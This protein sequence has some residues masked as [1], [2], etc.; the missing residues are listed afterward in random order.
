MLNLF[1]S[2]GP[3]S[4][5]DFV[6]V[7]HRLEMSERTLRDINRVF[8]SISLQQTLGCSLC[9]R[10]DRYAGY[11]AYSPFRVLS[12]QTFHKSRLEK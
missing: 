7:P 11:Q 4:G 9:A 5:M 8:L 12:D 10:G 6:S 3:L 1:Y 2:Y